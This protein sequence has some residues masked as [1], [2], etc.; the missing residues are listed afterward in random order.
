M[1]QN[2]D[3]L[4]FSSEELKVDGKIVIPKYQRGLVWKKNQRKAFI[5]T[6]FKGD[7]FGVVLVYKKEENVNGVKEVKYEVVDGLQ[8]LSTMKA[9]IERP[10][11]FIDFNDTIEGEDNLDYII[12]D[13]FDY[14]G[15][16]LTESLLKSNKK[17]LKKEM[18]SFVKQKGSSNS[19]EVWKHLCEKL[20]YNVNNIECLTKFNN[21]Y[22]NFLLK[23][24]FPNILI[25]AIVYTGPY[26][27]LPDVF[28]R[29]NTGSV[30]LTKYEI[31]ASIWKN[32][33]LL[34]NDQ[35][36]LDRVFNKYDV[37]S[38]KSS[39]EVQV[40]EEDLSQNG[41]T[42]FEYCYALSE[43]LNDDEKDYGNLFPGE[44]K[45]TDPTGFE[46]LSLICNLPV[47]N[48]N[49]L[50]ENKY[51]GNS[52][53][54]FL[55]KIKDALLDCVSFLYQSIR[56]VIVDIKGTEI[57]ND[58]TYQIYHMIVSIFRNLYDFDIVNKTITQKDSNV[59]N[60]F[61]SKFS[62]YAKKHY[63]Y[64]SISYYWSKNR[65][66]NDLDK[67]LKDSTSIN[68]YINNISRLDFEKAIKDYCDDL[69]SKAFTKSIDNE[70]KLLL[71][72][73]YR[74]LIKED[75]NRED[76]FKSKDGVYFDVEHITP[77]A[78]FGNNPKELPI[79]AFGNLCYLAV[80]DNR[81][82]R[83]KTI[84]QYADERP[85]LV[86]SDSFLELITYP[87]KEE[88]EFLDYSIDDFAISYIELLNKR[89]E[90]IIPRFIDLIMNSSLD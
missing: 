64:D 10:L 55:I 74:L 14:L 79:S 61:K 42:L 53:P 81:S 22:D 56:D 2:Y 24:K 44:K 36:I 18:L 27:E 38:K 72:Y 13:K 87:S 39:F 57:M 50:I 11:D 71:N 83:D 8:R 46:L 70:T 77:V 34:I 73:Y 15:R 54:Q 28:Q 31:Y 65:Q 90:I 21:Y 7:P 35:D 4:Q 67:L 60:A 16:N 59:V 1:A 6:V 23:L 62:K 43:I 33:M 20:E 52:T 88:L 26:D 32:T 29:L 85:S 86:I 25:P 5:N 89:E 66:V 45:S 30:K 17:A 48:S 84:Y 76:L 12:K 40:T 63:I 37:L 82:K 49:K 69:K 51:L 58:S 75:R 19:I 9:Y 41:I 68:K 78:K 47:N 3:I 80:K